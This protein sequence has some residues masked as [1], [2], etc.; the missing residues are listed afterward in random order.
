MSTLSR[1]DGLLLGARYEA[2]RIVVVPDEEL[3]PIVAAGR[4]AELLASRLG[5]QVGSERGGTFRNGQR[6]PDLTL[7]AVRM[8][9]WR[10]EE[11]GA[12]RCQGEAANA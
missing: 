2:V 12:Q 8:R 11:Q 1:G 5:H 6:D 9:Q 7:A 4:A 3:A 10:A